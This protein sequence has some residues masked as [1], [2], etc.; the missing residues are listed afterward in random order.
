MCQIMWF[1]Q[2]SKNTTTT[3]QKIKHKSLSEPGIEPGTSLNPIGCITSVPP[4]K[5][6]VLI[7]FK[8][9]NCLNEMGPNVNKQSWICGLHN[10]FFCNILTCMENYIWQFLIFT[11]GFTALIW[12]NYKML[13]IL[14]KRYRH[15]IFKV[16]LWM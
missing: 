16:D 1:R 6:K 9:F 13:T 11:E 5:L 15:S 10:F 7:V 8:L 14:T 12:L 4:S 2:K 3:K